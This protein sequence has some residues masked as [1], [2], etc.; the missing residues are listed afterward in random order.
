MR[1]V[2]CGRVSIR[3]IIKGWSIQNAP[4]I[5]AQ[6]AKESYG[7]VYSWGDLEFID[8]VSGMFA[9]CSNLNILASDAPKIG[10]TLEDAFANCDLTNSANVANWDISRV[11]NMRSAFLNTN[12]DINLA[13][14]NISSLTNA[15]NFMAGCTLSTTNYDNILKSWQLRAQDNADVNIHFGN[16]R[17]TA[18]SQASFGRDTLTSAPYNW[19]ITDGGTA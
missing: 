13:N 3:G 6:I 17:Y 15:T 4:N 14:W 5:V 8:D 10:N 19:T 18:N 2:F 9:G 11:A 16:S 1:L 12:I 7:N